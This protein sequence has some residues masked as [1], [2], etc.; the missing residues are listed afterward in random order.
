METGRK[1]MKIKS[2]SFDGE[3][4]TDVKPIQM[5][6]E[7]DAN[8]AMGGYTATRWRKKP[9]EI[10]AIRWTG[11]NKAAVLAFCDGTAWVENGVLRINTLEGSHIASVGDYIIRGVKG[12][13]Y[14]CKADV[15]MAT[16]ERVKGE[17]DV[18]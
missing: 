2:L 12:E 8:K 16:Y 6:N 10:D 17:C 18:L 3:H 4:W 1:K 11:K 14:P 15:F 9:V 7:A 13:Y 5:D